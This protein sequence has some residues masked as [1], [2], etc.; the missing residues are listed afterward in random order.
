MKKEQVLSVYINSDMSDFEI[1][2]L[3]NNIIKEIDRYLEEWRQDESFIPWY[4]R[5]P[6]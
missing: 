4:D 3:K 5:E 1:Q 2:T 6:F